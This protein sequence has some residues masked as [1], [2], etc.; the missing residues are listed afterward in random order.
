LSKSH[1]W[2]DFAVKAD[3]MNGET[4]YAG[5]VETV[6]TGFSDPLMGGVV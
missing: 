1:G 3:G 6:T 4:H 2:Y 5:R